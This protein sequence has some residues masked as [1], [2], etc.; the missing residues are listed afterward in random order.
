MKKKWF[1]SIAASLLLATSISTVASADESND[2]DCGD[3]GS[4]DEVVAYWNK[5]GYTATND[6]ENLDGRGKSVDDGIPC[7]APSGYDT[8]KINGLAVKEEEPAEQPAPVEEKAE[9]KTEEK[10]TESSIEESVSST[11]D[12]DKSTSEENKSSQEEGEALPDTASNGP[13]MLLV[14]VVV[15]G[16]G[17]VM[18]LAPK[19][20][21]I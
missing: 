19:K 2:K 16:L 3:F 21:R 10:T 6:P 17:L 13:L 1:A 9:E 11:D 7:E 20:R 15:A 12:Q 18:A 5:M 14:S 4:Y 8:S